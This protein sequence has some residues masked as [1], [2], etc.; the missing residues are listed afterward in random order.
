MNNKDHQPNTTHGN[1]QV[2]NDLHQDLK[3]AWE[4][5]QNL[6]QWGVHTKLG[7]PCLPLFNRLTALLELAG[8]SALRLHESLNQQDWNA[9]IK[10]E[11]Q[12]HDHLA[13]FHDRRQHIIEITTTAWNAVTQRREAAANSKA[14]PRSSGPGG[15]LPQSTPPETRE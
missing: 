13:Q 8:A 4:E 11:Q 6:L 12:A 9:A 10:A 14:A 7:N 15:A 3:H 5:Y 2:L 1:H